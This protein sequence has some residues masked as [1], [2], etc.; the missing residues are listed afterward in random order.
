MGLQKRCHPRGRAEKLKWCFNCEDQKLYHRIEGKWWCTGCWM[1][2][3]PTGKKTNART[4]N[5]AK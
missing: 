2:D 5:Q 3:R 1:N 4:R